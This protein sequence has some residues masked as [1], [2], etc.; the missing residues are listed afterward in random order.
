M[1]VTINEGTLT[2]IK[3]T[4]D[5]GAEIQHVRNDGGTVGVLS[6]LVTGTVARVG[7]VQNVNFGTFDTFYRHPD[8]FGTVVSTGTN[9]MGTIKAGIA[10][11]AIYVTDLIISAGSATNVEI[12]NGGT[13]LPLIGTLHLAANGGAVMNFNTPINTS[14]GSDL[15]YKQSTAISPLTIT[16]NGYID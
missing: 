10:G 16:C 12:G 7:T 13:S 3:T 5:S 9:T 11:S 15:V 1:S 6:N 14:A 4:T 2:A 8:R